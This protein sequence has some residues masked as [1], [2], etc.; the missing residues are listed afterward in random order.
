MS[1]QHCAI[2]YLARVT[3]GHRKCC[4]RTVCFWIAM[5]AFQPDLVVLID[6]T[7]RP[8]DL[9]VKPTERATPVRP[10]GTREPDG[11]HLN[12]AAKPAQFRKS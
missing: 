10:G 4:V 6:R 11:A 5:V 8:T 7:S 2:Q 9:C 3:R 12:T 1:D